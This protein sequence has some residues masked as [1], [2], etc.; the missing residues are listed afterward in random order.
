MWVD[1]YVL[2]FSEVLVVGG[3]IIFHQIPEISLQSNF[4]ICNVFLKNCRFSDL[5]SDS[6]S[7]QIYWK[8]EKEIVKKNMS[9]FVILLE[10]RIV[11]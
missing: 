8:L 4:T 7:N 5:T 6:V 2:L 1:A 11:M 9:V 3:V 10:R